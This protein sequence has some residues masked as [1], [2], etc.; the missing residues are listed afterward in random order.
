MDELMLV[1]SFRAERSVS[2]DAQERV[3]ARLLQIVDGESA[4]EARP[5]RAL[6]LRRR[7]SL[8]MVAVSLVAAGIVFGLLG[9]LPDSGPLSLLPGGGSS[10]VARAAAALTGPDGTIVHVRAD[11]LVTNVD[12]S[13]ATRPVEIWQQSSPPFDSREVVLRGGG[14]RPEL[15][16]VDGVREFY[17]PQTNTIYTA[18]S[19]TPAGE[20]G[21]PAE[22]R[23]GSDLDPFAPDFSVEK[24]RAL[25]GSGQAHEDGR[26]SVDGRAAI[27]IVSSASDMT[28]LVDADTYKPLEWHVAAASMAGHALSMRFETYE[29]LPATEANAA[30]VSLSAQ[31][32]GATRRT[33]PIDGAGSDAG[34]K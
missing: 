26:V 29:W 1:R 21:K 8:R 5:G 20:P 14:F 27:R 7:G 17:D 13:T 24:L 3:R 6:R 33:S 15:A 25:L 23:D 10:A 34:T 18:P 11:V 22:A 12:G 28:L 31:H 30:L 19:R 16:T 32:P 4:S 9:A 2:A